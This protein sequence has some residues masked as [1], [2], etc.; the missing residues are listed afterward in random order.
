MRISNSE[1]SRRYRAKNPIRYAYHNLKSN[2]KRRGKE[3]D[4][5]FEQFKEFCYKTN[6]IQGK[7]ITKDSYSIDRKDNDKGYTIDNIRILT[8]SENS[9]KGNK[10]LVFDWDYEERRGYFKV[11]QY[12]SPEPDPENPF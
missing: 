1:K 8:V 2:S 5:T 11:T 9:K 4:L 6:Y 12:T 10:Q 3:F 7:G